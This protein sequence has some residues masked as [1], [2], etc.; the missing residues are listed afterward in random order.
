MHT[1]HNRRE[2]QQLLSAQ[3]QHLGG[4]SNSKRQIYCKDINMIISI[5]PLVIPEE[6]LI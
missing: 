1:Q 6:Y 3:W 2:K 4:F 5:S